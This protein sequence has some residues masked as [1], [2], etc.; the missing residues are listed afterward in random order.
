MMVIIAALSDVIYFIKKHIGNCNSDKITD[1]INYRNAYY[2]T[3]KSRRRC[4]REQGDSKRRK[5]YGF[6][7]FGTV[8]KAV[9]RVCIV[10]A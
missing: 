3:C 5:F 8:N 2:N 4:C 9:Q 1:V 7:F 6:C 10:G